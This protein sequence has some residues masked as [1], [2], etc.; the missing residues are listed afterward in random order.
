MAREYS[1]KIGV[2]QENLTSVAISCPPE[3]T[4]FG[5]GVNQQHDGLMGLPP[6]PKDSRASSNYRKFS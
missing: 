3:S 4:T 6:V 1:Q 5:Q 2:V